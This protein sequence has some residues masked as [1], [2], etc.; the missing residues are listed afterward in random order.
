[1]ITL[2]LNKMFKKLNEYF[3]NLLS[4]NKSKDETV[5]IA[6][7]INPFNDTNNNISQSNFDYKPNPGKVINDESE[8]IHSLYKEKNNM[9]EQSMTKAYPNSE[10]LDDLTLISESETIKSNLDASKFSEEKKKQEHNFYTP[11]IPKTAKIFTTIPFFAW[12]LSDFV[13]GNKLG[14]GKFGKVYIA[15]EKSSQSIVALKV[16]SKK[17]LKVLLISNINRNIMLSIS[18]GGKSKFNHILIIRIFSS[19]T[20]FSGIIVEYT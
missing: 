9:I 20:E 16:L 2:N 18:L 10:V 4:N 17:Q 6:K 11:D 1:M 15:K 19:F 13:I 8:I 5:M 12:S 7:E 3:G 14:S